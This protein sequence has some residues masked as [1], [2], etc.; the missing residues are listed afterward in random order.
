MT[1]NQFKNE[2]LAGMKAHERELQDCLDVLR[3]QPHLRIEGELDRIT[4]VVSTLSKQV[5]NVESFINQFNP[6]TFNDKNPVTA[7]M[8]KELADKVAS[9]ISHARW[10]FFTI[11]NRSQ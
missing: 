11:A 1:L 2:I 9:S 6:R 3:K 8:L 10:D 5:L 7:D 4:D